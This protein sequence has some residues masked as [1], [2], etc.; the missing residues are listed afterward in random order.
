MGPIV[1]HSGSTPLISSP[2]NS[3]TTI[4]NPLQVVSLPKNKSVS[5]Q[6]NT[7]LKL[8]RTWTT[9]SFNKQN[10][11]RIEN[12]LLGEGTYGKA[13]LETNGSR[14]VVTKYF[15]EPEMQI[16]EI[17]GEIAILR[18]LKG[19]PYT[20]QIIK[21]T[22][23]NSKR[24]TT[25]NEKRCAV[26]PCLVMKAEQYSLFNWIQNNPTNNWDVVFSLC[27]D[28]LQGYNLLHSLGIVH[29]DTKPANILITKSTNAVITDFGSS[30]F[31]LP[32][33]PYVQHGYTG[34]I[35]YSSPEVL[36]RHILQYYKHSSTY[37]KRYTYTYK[38]G[39]AQDAWA[40]GIVLFYLLTRSTIFFSN[41]DQQNEVGQLLQILTAKG[42]ITQADG[43]V[44]KLLV[45]YVENLYKYFPPEDKVNH[46]K[47]TDLR[48]IMYSPPPSV[49]I[50]QILEQAI[51]SNSS[52]RK[53]VPI[54]LGLLEYNPTT[55]FT[56]NKALTSIVMTPAIK[57]YTPP[58]PF[59]M[60]MTFTLK[61]LSPINLNPHYI[62]IDQCLT[63]IVNTIS[64]INNTYHIVFD[65]ACLF[66]LQLVQTNTIYSSPELQ[67]YYYIV[68]LLA[69]ALFDDMR[70]E[71][72]NKKSYF[73]IL[74]DWIKT[75]P[76]ISP[77]ISV[78][79]LLKNIL[80]LDIT[81]LETTLLDK[82]LE[83]MMPLTPEKIKR[84]HEI[85][86]YCFFNNLYTT[87]LQSKTADELVTYLC[88]F[89]KSNASV[90]SLTPTP[91]PTTS[92]G[93]NRPRRKRRTPKKPR[94][95]VTR[96]KRAGL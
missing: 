25:V 69:Y 23:Q 9:S 94:K 66:F 83:S 71:T 91:P 52:C 95:S 42:T 96:R 39:L 59:D 21:T 77:K 72:Y 88:E 78:L 58:A 76:K 82:M 36:M 33:I 79:P 4:A 31:T 75:T 47:W 74:L 7:H 38:D 20:S 61:L 54:V 55:R 53:L 62:K 30:V 85:N 34:T 8:N 29:Q 50:Q 64:L 92:S 5:P 87:L 14:K 40:V 11:V 89:A 57:I 13:V 16:G 70:Y 35:W 12:T 81:F 45:K 60:Y 65:R 49:S 46:K 2:A 28:I 17:I 86:K 32:T 67:K 37:Y 19:L 63:E 56:I 22:N 6:D 93:G 10:T 80:L 84:V 41:G 90:E 43:D 3:T 68:I 48:T 73:D 15:I 51:P 18:Y 27:I 26:V 44:H 24:Q 1:S